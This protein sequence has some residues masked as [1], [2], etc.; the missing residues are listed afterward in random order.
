MRDKKPH[1]EAI[2]EPP[3][4]SSSKVTLGDLE[5][6]A[7]AVLFA[8]TSEETLTQI[9]EQSYIHKNGFIKLTL[10]KINGKK[11]RVHIFDVD[12][13]ADQNVHNHRWDFTSKVLCGAL[14]M[15]LYKVI[16]GKEYYFHTYTRDENTY[17]VAHRGFCGLVE[18][19]L[20]YF[21]AGMGYM[22]PKEIH[23]RIGAVEELT[24][25]YMVTEETNQFTC[26]LINL[27]DKSEGGE[28]VIEP[29]L[30]SKTVFQSLQLVLARIQ[31][32]KE[33]IKMEMA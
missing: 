25:T 23:H 1:T 3:T 11:Y 7:T 20:Q 5:R 32:L 4:L 30:D 33:Q 13:K 26:D 10:A 2:Y 19:P 14:P 15:Y 22:M 12:A 24:I 17:T 31:I 27:E 6:M 8:L 21:N 29:P 9:G 28:A 18:A 16:G